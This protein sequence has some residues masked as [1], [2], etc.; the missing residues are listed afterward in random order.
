M[1]GKKI[2]YR[3]SL[4]HVN[5]IWADRARVYIAKNIFSRGENLYLIDG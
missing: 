3:V 2:L 4:P 5:I 1:A